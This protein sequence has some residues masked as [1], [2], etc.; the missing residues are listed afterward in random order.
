MAR[1]E[2]R[3]GTALRPATLAEVA[4]LAGVSTATVARV[5]KSSGYVSSEARGRVEAAIS[6]KGYRPNAIARGL[7]Q[8]RSFI[9]GHILTSITVN[10]FF[11]NV[12]HWAEEEALK[13]G[14]K[15]FL[16]NH[17]GSRERERL[18]IERFIERRV[19]AVLFTNAL[20]KKMSGCSRMRTY[21]R[22]NWNEWRPPRRLR[23]ES[24]I[25]SAR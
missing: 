2:E 17:N 15:T 19:D 24:T 9:V 18:G 7:R 25:E 21:R 1:E 16:F 12:A 10:P 3:L 13:H 22:F 8:R 23:F 20:S 11:V 5:I 6:A 4:R 14:Y